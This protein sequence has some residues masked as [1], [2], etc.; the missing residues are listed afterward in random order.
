MKKK[1]CHLLS[2]GRCHLGN[3]YFFPFSLF[4]SLPLSSPPVGGRKEG[5]KE[6]EGEAAEAAS[7]AKN[8]NLAKAAT[9]KEKKNFRRRRRRRTTSVT[10]WHILRQT[11]HVC[12]AVW[13]IYF[14]VGILIHESGKISCKNSAYASCSEVAALRTESLSLSLGPCGG[15]FS[16]SSSPPLPL[17]L[18]QMQKCRQD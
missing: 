16:F 18:R 7:Q 12:F 4:L 6:R 9:L 3:Q 13:R 8:R 10:N 2:T 17:S 5:R 14:C 1:S 11:W 15:C